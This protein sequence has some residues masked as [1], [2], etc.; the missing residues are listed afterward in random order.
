M[1]YQGNNPVG[2]ALAA[3][4]RGE[5]RDALLRTLG[6]Y[7]ATVLQEL[8]ASSVPAIYQRKLAAAQCA[9]TSAA[10]VK[11]FHAICVPADTEH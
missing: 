11:E 7:E 5:L 8:K 2:L 9:A 10:M 1:K 4:K 6:D 3:D